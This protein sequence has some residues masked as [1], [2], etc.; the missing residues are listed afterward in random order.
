MIETQMMNNAQNP[1][2]H[3]A[4]VSGSSIAGFQTP[5]KVC[6]ESADYLEEK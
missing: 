4:D 6:T 3:I 5:E 1:L 2:L